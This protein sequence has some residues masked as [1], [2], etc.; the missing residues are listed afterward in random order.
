MNLSPQPVDIL[1]FDNSFSKC[2]IAQGKIFK[3]KKVVLIIIL[4]WV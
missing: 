2:D 4:L 1:S 3:G